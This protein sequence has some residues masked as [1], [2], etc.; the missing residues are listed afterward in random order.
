MPCVY[1]LVCFIPLYKNPK[2]V[3]LKKYLTDLGVITD[4]LPISISANRTERI[5]E[6]T[7]S[8]KLIFLDCMDRKRGEIEQNTGEMIKLWFIQEAVT[9]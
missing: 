3:S 6:V 9:S 1:R 8:D 5:V 2:L 4:L 7:V